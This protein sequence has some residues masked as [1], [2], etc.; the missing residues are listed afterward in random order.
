MISLNISNSFS[1]DIDKHSSVEKLVKRIKKKNRKE[2][3][4]SNQYNKFKYNGLYLKKDMMGKKFVVDNNK[5][6]NK[7]LIE[8]FND[9]LDKNRCRCNSVCS[10][11]HICFGK[12]KTAIYFNRTTFVSGKGP[13]KFP[14][15]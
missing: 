1:V 13:K 10:G 5:S 3:K 15:I 9:E 11:K 12:S 8:F 14:Y 7:T 6:L 2:N 4:N